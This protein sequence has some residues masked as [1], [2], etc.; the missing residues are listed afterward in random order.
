MVYLPEI[1][2][3]LYSLSMKEDPTQFVFFEEQDLV[4]IHSFLLVRNR[5]LAEKFEALLS[6][7]GSKHGINKKFE[8]EKGT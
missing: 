1:D 2:G 7:V 6:S 8:D 4:K 3:R 5:G